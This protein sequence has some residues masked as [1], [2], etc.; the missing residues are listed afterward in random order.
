[1]AVRLPGSQPIAVLDSLAQ[2]RYPVS[3]VAERMSQKATPSKK[4]I[5]IRAPGKNGPPQIDEEFDDG[6]DRGSSRQCAA[7]A[8]QE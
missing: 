6:F 8:D 4:P 7:S 5:L 1:M 2:L 3:R